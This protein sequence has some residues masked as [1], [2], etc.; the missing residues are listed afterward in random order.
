VALAIISWGHTTPND[1]PDKLYAKANLVNLV[2]W[3]L[4]WPVIVLATVLLGRVWCTVCPLELISNSF[5][6]VGRLLGIAQRPVPAWMRAGWLM[7]ALYALLQLL[8]SGLH[9]HRVPGYTSA[10]LWAMLAAAAVYRAVV[11]GS[12]LLPRFLPGGSAAESVWPRWHVG[13]ARSRS[14]RLPGVLRQDLRCLRLSLKARRAQLPDPPESAHYQPQRGTSA[15]R[16]MPK[17]LS[18]PEHA[19]AVP[20][21]LRAPGRSSSDRRLAG[22]PFRGTRLRFCLVGGRQ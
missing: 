19:T 16:A 1:V 11:A 14:I 8:V 22:R 3:G 6:R 15:L 4:F 21:T 18:A 9:L 7:L 20:P 12:C 17:E 5:E 10:F 13:R 2:V